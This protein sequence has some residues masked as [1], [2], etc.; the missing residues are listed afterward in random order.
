MLNKL[1]ALAKLKKMVTPR[2]MVVAAL[3]GVISVYTG[4]PLTTV[5][6]SDQ[7]CVEQE[8]TDGLAP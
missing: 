8:V 1:V 5:P 4:I 3:V 2:D 6:T 7:S